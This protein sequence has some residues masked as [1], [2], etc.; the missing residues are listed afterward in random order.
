MPPMVS[1]EKNLHIWRFKSGHFGGQICKNFQQFVLLQ[2]VP[3]V[4]NKISIFG[5]LK[6]LIFEKMLLL[7]MFPKVIWGF[8]MTKFAKVAYFGVKKAHFGGQ[9]CKNL[10]NLFFAPHAP[11]SHLGFSNQHHLVNLHIWGVKNAHFVG[12]NAHGS[13]FRVSH[14]QNLHFCQ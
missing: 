10:Q 14:D 13:H 5:V 11:K 8:H 7:Q 2:M 12:P 9:K 4:T 6:M 1:H 3:K